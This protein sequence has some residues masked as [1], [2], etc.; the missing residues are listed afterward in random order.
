MCGLKERGWGGGGADRRRTNTSLCRPRQMGKAAYAASF[1]VNQSNVAGRSSERPTDASDAS[2]RLLLVLGQ[3]PSS[4]L[5][6]RRFITQINPSIRD[7]MT[8]D[9]SMCYRGSNSV[10]L[11]APSHF[12]TLGPSSRVWFGLLG[13]FFF[14]NWGR[15]PTLS[16]IFMFPL[17]SHSLRF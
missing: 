6:F 4:R 12:L 11:A 13:C 15:P 17:I 9:A 10:S 1:L 14:R 2:Q 8:S 3:R 5:Q 7:K 16:T